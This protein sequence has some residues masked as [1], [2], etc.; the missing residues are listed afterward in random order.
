VSDLKICGPGYRSRYSD[1]LRAGTV[2]GSNPGGGEIF[3]THPHRPWGPRSLLYNGYRVSFQA[4]KWPGRGVD[5][6]PPSS[7]EI[8]ERV[9][10]YLYYP[11]GP[12]LPVLVW[13]LPLTFYHCFFWK[14]YCGACE[15]V[16]RS[17]DWRKGT[18]LMYQK[19][20]SDKRAN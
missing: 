19:T 1:S 14:L 6:P 7:A 9:E 13:T 11:S 5:H 20:H 3:R 12:S 10:L 2:R 16:E 4:V 17:L 8:K 18:V 15:K